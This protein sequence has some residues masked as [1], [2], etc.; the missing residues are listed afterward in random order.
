M[1]G[2]FRRGL[3]AGILLLAA[4]LLAGGCTSFIPGV[5]E[6]AGRALDGSAFAEKTLTRYQS[7]KAGD[8]K[9]KAKVESEVR[10]MMNTQ[11]DVSLVILLAEFPAIR[12]R[13]SEPAGNGDF[14]LT[15][16]E[17]LGG[18]VSGWNE[19]TLELSGA[20]TFVKTGDTATLRFSG[21]P[22]PV[23]ISSGKIR[24]SDTRITGSEAL[25]GLRNRYE[26]ILALTAWMREREG[27]PA[28]TGYKAFEAYWR[29]VL[30][31]ETVRAKRRPPEWNKDGGRRVWAE[32]IGWNTAYTERLF[33]EELRPLRDSGALL[34]DWEEAVEWIYFE[35]SREKIGGYFSGGIVMQRIK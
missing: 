33:P 6:Q 20:G 12:F 3:P 35:Y 11:G 7:R 32:D 2:F 17:Y 15:G 8:G 9:K 23:Q 28:F 31:P 19:F 14:Y 25:T 16:L 13:G 1:A 24:R 29:A 27:V 22:E 21:P 4:A 18:N 26:R 34:R 10:E 30:L 5:V